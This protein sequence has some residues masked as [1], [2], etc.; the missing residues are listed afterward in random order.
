MEPWPP[1]HYSDWA[2]T[3]QTLHMWTQIVGKVRMVKSPQLN[4]SWHVPLY[5]TARGLSTSP[6]PNGADLFEIAFDFVDHRL[7]ITT[8]EGEERAFSLRPMTVAAF[9]EELM[10]ALAELRITVRIN[11]IPSEVADKVKRAAGSSFSTASTLTVPA[12]KLASSS[13]T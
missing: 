1:L 11:P 7:R 10:G 3:A 6:V 13:S 4:H 9:Y 8:S 12:R 5:V 2:D